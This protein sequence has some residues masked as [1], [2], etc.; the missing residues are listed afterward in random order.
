MT[1]LVLEALESGLSPNEALP[2]YSVNDLHNIHLSRL[3]DA[4][5]GEF[6]RQYADGKPIESAHLRPQIIKMALGFL[7]SHADASL[8]L[9][10]EFGQSLLRL[11]QEKAENSH[12]ALEIKR[13][14]LPRSITLIE[15]PDAP[16]GALRLSE[17]T[18]EKSLRGAG[19]QRGVSAASHWNLWFKSFVAEV[20]LCDIK[21][22]SE[23]PFFNVL[24]EF[25]RFTALPVNFAKVAAASQVSQTT[26]TR[27]CTLFERLAL[28][29]WVFPYHEGFE[30]RHLSVKPKTYWNAPS[31]A[32]WLMRFIYGDLERGG[33][34]F[35]R[36]IEN[37]LYLALKDRYAA[38]VRFG[39]LMDNNAR[40]VPL[41]LELSGTKHG[42]YVI[43]N[44]AAL[45]IARR[46]AK[47]YAKIHAIDRAYCLDTRI[48]QDE[49]GAVQLPIEP[50]EF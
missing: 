14:G 5:P 11:V 19:L 44:D 31:L 8:T 12:I 36:L 13:Y 32:L 40:D 25:S 28:I 23:A 24:R 27:W 30:K 18:L 7:L 1:T 29:D 43:S 37:A 38:S 33:D 6:F 26:V 22:R 9:R 16:F 10:G 45:S 47:S 4:S 48:E 2:G 17:R 39:F 15:T 49:D 3:F 46:N 35:N 41:I 34:V 20:G 42:F 21:V 50:L